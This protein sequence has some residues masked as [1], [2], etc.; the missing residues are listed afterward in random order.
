M[1]Y[2]LKNANSTMNVDTAKVIERFREHKPIYVAPY[3]EEARVAL[4]EN[5]EA[6]GFKCDGNGISAREVILTSRYPLVIDFDARKFSVMGNTTVAAGAASSKVVI[7]EK[8]YYI[9]EEV[10]GEKE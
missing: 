1:I 6:K 5:L 2:K 4:I 7:G 9:L 3:D 8:E 10:F